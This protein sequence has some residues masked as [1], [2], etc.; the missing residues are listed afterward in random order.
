MAEIKPIGNDETYGLRG[1]QFILDMVR[2]DLW[3]SYKEDHPEDLREK[4]RE[5]VGIID[6]VAER[7]N[8]SLW[9]LERA[10]REDIELAKKKE[11][12]SAAGK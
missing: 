10:E 6:V 5:V 9:G 12:Q 7:M 3:E 2:R 4:V 1:C 8:E 11:P